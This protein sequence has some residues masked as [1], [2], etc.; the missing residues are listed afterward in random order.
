[1]FHRR[2]FKSDN[3]YIYSRLPVIRTCTY[4]NNSVIRSEMAFPLDLLTQL[5]QKHSRLFELQLFELS[6]IRSD[7]YSPWGQLQ[8]KSPSVI[9]IFLPL[10]ERWSLF[11]ENGLEI[12]KQLNMITRICQKHYIDSKKQCSI[13]DFFKS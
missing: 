12:R 3:I 10:M 9:R 13:K 11:D 7:F 1:M 4:S 5:R 6:V 2:I 8:A